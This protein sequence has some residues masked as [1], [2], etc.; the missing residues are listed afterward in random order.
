MFLAEVAIE[1]IFVAAVVVAV[2]CLAYLLTLTVKEQR[3]LHDMRAGVVI[4]RP[5][6]SQAD[7][8]PTLVEEAPKRATVLS[9]R[10]SVPRHAVSSR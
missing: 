3:I 1:L 6:P 9:L 5:K 4:Y 10:P 2:A 7:P 8:E